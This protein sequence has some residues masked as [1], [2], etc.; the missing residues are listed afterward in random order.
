MRVDG[1]ILKGLGHGFVDIT[2]VQVAFKAHR[3]TDTKVGS[4]AGV[5]M[6]LVEQLLD[7]IF[8]V[9][10]LK[11]SESNLAANGTVQGSHVVELMA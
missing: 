7:R 1:Q 6:Q 10:A 11:I 3:A 9:I 4:Q 8:D 2:E 5:V